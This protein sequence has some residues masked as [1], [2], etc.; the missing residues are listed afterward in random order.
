M[1]SGIADSVGVVVDSR[2]FPKTA[3]Q[4]PWNVFGVGPYFEQVEIVQ[5]FSAEVVSEHGGHR[6]GIA[7]LLTPVIY[8]SMHPGGGCVL[9]TPAAH[10]AFRFF[11][12]PFFDHF[13]EELSVPGHH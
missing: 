3:G 6:S 9:I 2:Y 5:L 1:V 13:L 10:N 8:R 11:S 12:W 7:F 4:K